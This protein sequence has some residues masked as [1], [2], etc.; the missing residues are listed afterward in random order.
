M[1]EGKLRDKN[2]WRAP[3]AAPR[4]EY[5]CKGLWRI[6]CQL[7]VQPRLRFC[8]PKVISVCRLHWHQ[9]R[10]W[11]VVYIAMNCYASKRGSAEMKIK[12]NF[13]PQRQNHGSKT[14][15]KLQVVN[16]HSTNNGENGSTLMSSPNQWVGRE[17]SQTCYSVAA[18]VQRVQQLHPAFSPA[19]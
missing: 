7:V 16:G 19:R 12:Q 8:C 11:K 9:Q 18:T 17:K 10:I 6:K 1:P 2:H 3:P 5:I 13:R 4:E 15:I 14:Q